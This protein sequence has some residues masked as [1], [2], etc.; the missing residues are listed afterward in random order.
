M[1]KEKVEVN[2]LHSFVLP[3]VKNWQSPDQVHFN[4]AGNVKLG[5]RVG[6]FIRRA[7]EDKAAAPR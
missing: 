1:Q 3:H 2:D 7:L 6:A 5:E 4:A